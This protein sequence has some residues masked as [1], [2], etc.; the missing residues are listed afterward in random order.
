VKTV[1]LQ[2]GDPADLLA[3]GI[4]P[5]RF[6]TSLAAWKAANPEPKEPKPLGAVIET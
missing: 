6:Y 4:E 1:Y 2:C 3:N 5:K